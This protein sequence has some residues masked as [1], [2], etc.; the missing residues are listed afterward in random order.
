MPITRS[1]FFAF[2]ISASVSADGIVETSSRELSED[3]PQTALVIRSAVNR[4]PV[5][6]VND[7]RVNSLIDT[8]S[9][10]EG[11]LER[12]QCCIA[13]S[14]RHERKIRYF[15]ALCSLLSALL[16]SLSFVRLNTQQSTQRASLFVSLG[17]PPTSKRSPSAKGQRAPCLI[18]SRMPSCCFLVK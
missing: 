13:L 2:S 1:T 14:L 7:E 18:Q 9:K 4:L 17:P 11:Y 8:Q 3:E 16:S 6:G 15:L 10:K 12:A 5:W